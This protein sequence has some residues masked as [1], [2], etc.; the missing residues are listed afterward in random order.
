MSSTEVPAGRAPDPTPRPLCRG[1]AGAPRGRA[2]DPRPPVREFL[3]SARG[4]LWFWPMTLGV[5]A[6]VGAEL[7]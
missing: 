2:R 1:G 4:G 5:L 7:V 3:Q 6:A